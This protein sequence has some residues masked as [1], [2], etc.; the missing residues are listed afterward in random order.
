MNVTSTLIINYLSLSLFKFL[1]DC[2][3]L[4]S[5]YLY[6]HLHIVQHGLTEQRVVASFESHHYWYKSRREPSSQSSLYIN[7]LYRNINQ[8]VIT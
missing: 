7:Y 3:I 6:N 2:I 1:I 4:C 5:I 8:N